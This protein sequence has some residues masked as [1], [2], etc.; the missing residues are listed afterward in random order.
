M[1]EG[2]VTC[3][4]RACGLSRLAA[5]CPVMSKWVCECAA[6]WDLGGER[7]GATVRM[8]GLVAGLREW[9]RVR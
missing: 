8:L 1:A 9:R 4:A 2:Q 5:G 6:G 3:V 7:R